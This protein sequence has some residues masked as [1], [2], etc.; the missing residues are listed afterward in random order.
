MQQRS[1]GQTYR[2]LLVIW[3]ALLASQLMFVGMVYS[4][5]P[6]LREIDSS[7]PILGDQPITILGLAVLAITDVL[8]SIVIRRYLYKKA[9]A[10]QDPAHVQTGLVI[11]CALCEMSS[12]LG[13]VLA[14]GLNYQY[15][16]VFSALGIFGTV[17]HFPQRGDVAAATYRK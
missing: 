1:A 10:E 16:F 17:L 15:F 13:V 5:R 6:D 7:R 11:A 2:T 3:V 8:L 12:L 9:E 4:V 14:L